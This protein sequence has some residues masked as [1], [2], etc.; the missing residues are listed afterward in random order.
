M[1]YI[2]N[3]FL[4]IFL[5]IGGLCLL[6]PLINGLEEGKSFKEIALA[7]YSL[8]IVVGVVMVFI[9]YRESRARDSDE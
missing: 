2:K 5:A 1:K 4:G 7:Y 9:S 6:N 3:T 8:F